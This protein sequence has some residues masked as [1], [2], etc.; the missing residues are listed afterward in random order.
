[1]TM[2]ADVTVDGRPES[3]FRLA[4]ESMLRAGDADQAARA[5][6]AEL[7][8]LC[9]EGQPLPAR[10]R[11][12]AASELEVTGWDRLIE[13]IGELDSPGDPITAIGIDVCGM[14][15]GFGGAP[16]LAFETT[17]YTDQAWGF[18]HADRDGLCAGYTGTTNA[19]QGAFEDLDD[20]L[21]VAGLDDLNA[22]IAALE[23]HCRSGS[24][25][26]EEQ[27]GFVVG[28]CYLAV[29][30]HQAVRDKVTAEGL[31]RAMAVLVGSNEAYPWFEAP[32]AS[33][34]DGFVS[35]E[36]AP[37]ARG[38]G[39]V[40]ERRPL[41]LGAHLAA[42]PAPPSHLPSLDLPSSDLTPSDL[43]P[44]ELPAPIFDTG[45]APFAPP[46]AQ[47]EASTETAPPLFD[48][49]GQPSSADELPGSVF[50]QFPQAQER[51][52]F[53]AADFEA[54]GFDDWP[55]ET[56][57]H[58]LESEET[59]ELAATDAAT[60][61]AALDGLR[62]AAT[63][64]PATAPLPVLE[65]A[66]E[67]MPVQEDEE[68]LHLPPPGIHV[69]GTQLRRRFVDRETIAI[70]EERPASLVSSLLERLFGKK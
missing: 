56:Q 49:P 26:P 9:G 41:D 43:Q 57:H 48:A 55:A 2:L 1:M 62:M 3:Q 66:R 21:R 59:A 10:F 67:A 25:T 19:W 15:A 20:T 27:R 12:I 38:I 65:P 17:Y 22:V 52:D 46:L 6:K 33:A 4:I 34:R 47:D 63:A 29:L 18:S 70:E 39:A 51:I 13:R 36:P 35:A 61:Y 31:P 69:T 53:G 45:R 28:A 64:T 44:T 40:L 32:A 37:A 54:A 8:Y 16:T 58:D 7:G 50:R 11:F 30:V 24:A 42:M 5:L 23:N 68:A 14:Q 60:D